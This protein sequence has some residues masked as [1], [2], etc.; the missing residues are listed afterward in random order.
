[1]LYRLATL[2]LLALTLA[3]PSAGAAEA[4]P[5]PIVIAHRGASGYRP[6]HTEAAYRLAAEQGADYIEADLVMTKDGV[7]VSRHENE[8]GLTTDVA[9]H[10][11]F[12]DRR[13]SRL[14][15]GE[16][17]EG[18]FVEDFTLAELRTLRARER[19]PSQRTESAA[20]DGR[21]PVLTLAEIVAIARTEGDRRGRPV[22]LYIELKN[23]GYHAAIG[24]PM[25][26]ALVEAL[27]RAGLNRRD[28]PV[29]IQSFW[30]EALVAL[31]KLTPVRL[32]FLINSVPPPDDILRANGIAA[33][34]DVYSPEGLRY[35]A[36]F[37]EIVGPE[38]EL[39]FPRDAEGRSLPA[40]SFV[41]DAHDAGLQVHVWSVG[42][43]N[44]RLPVQFRRGD[45]GDPDHL[46]QPGDAAALVRALQSAGVDGLF[47][48]H[49]D[50]AV[51]ALRR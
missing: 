28:A 14:I 23:P 50:V 33:W 17:F 6:E 48:D 27:E 11:E 5:S 12:A 51:A 46:D 43:E 16:R 41:A 1:M 32:M 40:T 31:R 21:Q 42:A 22:G 47:T 37:A 38:T 39:I 24:L 49:P 35:V 2:A 3:T 25:E 9:A 7:L 18:W 8:I 4:F 19:Y 44:R 15:D 26:A 34:S 45:P 30:P 10:P 29:I 13:T 36:Q 20:Y